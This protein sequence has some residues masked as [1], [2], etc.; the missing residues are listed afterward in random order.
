MQQES[1]LSWKNV[2]SDFDVCEYV[3]DLKLLWKL[4]L[5][6]SLGTQSLKNGVKKGLYHLLTHPPSLSIV[7]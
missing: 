6:R 2:P 5:K 7:W 3:F 4:N 1:I